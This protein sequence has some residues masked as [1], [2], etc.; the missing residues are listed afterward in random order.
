LLSPVAKTLA[1][2]SWDGTVKLW[3]AQTGQGRATLTGHG[4][5]V[6]S[7]A[8][9]PDSKTLA[10]ASLDKTVKLWGGEIEEVEK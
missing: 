7:V 3:D 1:R 5:G 6:D 9:S 2:A 10:S 4:G 8:F